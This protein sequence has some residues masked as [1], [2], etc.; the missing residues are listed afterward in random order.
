MQEPGPGR[1]TSRVRCFG[2]DW[3]LAFDVGETG[4]KQ[5]Y[6]HLEKCPGPV[7][8]LSINAT[9]RV[10]FFSIDSPGAPQT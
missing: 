10:T 6:L 5:V 9:G 3:G 4:F 8:T 2:C 7:V 1:L